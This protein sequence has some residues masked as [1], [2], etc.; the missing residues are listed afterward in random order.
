VA[1]AVGAGVAVGVA[2]AVLV[3]VGEGWVVGVGVGGSGVADGP[4]ACS[5]IAPKISM[6]HAS[7]VLFMVYTS[8]CDSHAHA[9]QPFDLVPFSRSM[10]VLL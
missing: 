2:V 9:L 8:S 1:V 5:S 6:T 7:R 4:H 10:A 3:G